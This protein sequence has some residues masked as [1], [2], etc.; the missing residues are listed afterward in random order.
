MVNRCQE[1][2]KRENQKP[3][4]DAGSEWG[5]TL[6]LE[7]EGG[8]KYLPSPKWSRKKNLKAGKNLEIIE[9]RRR[10]EPKEGE[11][12]YGSE[13]RRENLRKTG[14]VSVNR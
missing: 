13:N 8:S 9:S 5:A 10:G 11:V 4:R 6:G 12:V 7:G 3:E 14:S 1:Q 2:K